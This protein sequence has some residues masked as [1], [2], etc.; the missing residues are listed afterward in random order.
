MVIWNHIHVSILLGVASTLGV[1][2]ATVIVVLLEVAVLPL[3]LLVIV[4]RQLFI[5]TLQYIEGL[6]IKRCCG[7]R[8]SLAR[9]KSTIRHMIRL[10]NRRISSIPRLYNSQDF[11]YHHMPSLAG[12]AK[13]HNQ[14]AISRWK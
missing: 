9:P 14:I 5:L 13:A 12:E 6:L 11:L 8:I 3:E 4:S 7:L 2:L 1:R 10:Q